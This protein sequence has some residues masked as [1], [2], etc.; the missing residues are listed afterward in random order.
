MTAPPA[1]QITLTAREGEPLK[2]DRIR[3][4]VIATAHAIA[5]RQGIGVQDIVTSPSSITAVL[6]TGR[7]E[8]IGFAAELRRLTTSWY[9]RKFGADTLWGEPPGDEYDADETWK[10]A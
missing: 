9:T 8:A 1:T 6:E 5:E 10:S 2:N 7:I 3:E 4:M